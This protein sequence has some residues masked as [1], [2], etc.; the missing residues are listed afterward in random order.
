MR[1]ETHVRWSRH[2]GTDHCIDLLFRAPHDYRAHHLA[3]EAIQHSAE[4]AGQL[5]NLDENVGRV[6][7]ALKDT[8]QYDNTIIVF[9][10]DNGG[11]PKNGASNTPLRGGKNTWFEGGTR[12]P[13]WMYSPLFDS[14]FVPSKID[15]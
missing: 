8:D 7:Q 5:Y 6:V 1:G 9:G 11:Q 3:V 13:A 15:W 4:Y 12:V 2:S 10:S 14:S